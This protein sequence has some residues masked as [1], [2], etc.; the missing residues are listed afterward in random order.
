MKKSARIVSFSLLAACLFLP[1]VASSEKPEK[2]N[3]GGKAMDHRSERAEERS[4]AQWQEDATRGRGRADEGGSRND[5]ID[6]PEK[7]R[8]ERE[9]KRDKKHADGDKGAKGD[10]GSESNNDREG[11]REEDRDDDESAEA[12]DERE[13]ARKGREETKKRGFWQRTFG[14]GDPEA[15]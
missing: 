5:D 12:A 15:E 4:N 7:A 6:E 14:G 1:G 3:R 9:K 10:K 2:G 8:D 13:D 11:R